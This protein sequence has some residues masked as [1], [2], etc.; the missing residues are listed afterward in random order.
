MTALS[1]PRNPPHS[2]IAWS[3][4]P[5]TLGRPVFTSAQSESIV[6]KLSSLKVSTLRRTSL[7]KLPFFQFILGKLAKKLLTPPFLVE[8][9]YPEYHR[10]KCYNGTFVRLWTFLL[11]L[12]ST[13]NKAGRG[14]P[15]TH[16][17]LIHNQY[18]LAA[19]RT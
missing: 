11:M 6:S 1:V 9:R 19:D 8:I 10:V 13:N 14:P 18:N 5:A 15:Q 17:I 3:C 4:R 7:H 16:L 12:R 2:D